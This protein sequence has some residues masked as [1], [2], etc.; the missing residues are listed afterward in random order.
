MT[1][2]LSPK[3]IDTAIAELNAQ[4]LKLQCDQERVRVA[5]AHKIR[6]GNNNGAKTTTTTKALEA[7]LIEM[8]ERHSATSRAVVALDKVYRLFGWTRYYLVPDGHIHGTQF[9]STFDRGEFATDVRWLPQESGRTAEDMINEY[10]TAMCTVCFPDAPAAPAY[11]E[12]IRKTEA[13]K[14]AARDERAAKRQAAADATPKGDDGQP[15]KVGLDT[16][17]TLLGARNALS[18]RLKNI[19]WYMEMH[20]H[21]GTQPSAGT[22]GEDGKTLNECYIIS[23]SIARMTG[24]VAGDV[25]EA[26]RVKAEKSAKAEFAKALRDE[27][28]RGR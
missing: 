7:R 9:C 3:A 21:N 20:K 25:Y 12:A 17:K 19:Y 26:A 16:P 4:A 14:Q 28:K 1:T 23:R 22:L 24:E 13:D 11:T 2:D 27:A 8:L 18:Y 5:I 15:L 10:T 6:V